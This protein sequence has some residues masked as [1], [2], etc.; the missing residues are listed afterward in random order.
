MKFNHQS[1]PLQPTAYSLQPESSGLLAAARQRIAIAPGAEYGPAKRWPTDRFRNVMDQLSTKHE[2]DWILVGTAAE[3]PIAKE[4]LT[5]IFYGHVENKVGETSLA[6]LIQLLQTCD[7]LLTNDT[8]TMHLADVLEIPTVAIFGSTDP[9]LTG[10]QG[11]HHRILQHPVSCSPCF[12]RKCPI[13]FR[14]MLG[15]TPEEVATAIEEQ[16]EL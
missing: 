16:L 8:G 15:V 9:T 4:I 5:P 14:C 2:I 1:Q 10:P 3:R 13:D 11:P 6:E 12:L 7:L